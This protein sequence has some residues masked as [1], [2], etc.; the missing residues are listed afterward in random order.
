MKKARVPTPFHDVSKYATNL[1]DKI[2]QNREA[3]VL[4]RQ[5]KAPER[6]KSESHF[7]RS[8]S[9]LSPQ[10]SSNSENSDDLLEGLQKSV[11]NTELPPCRLKEAFLSCS[12]EK[13]GP[14]DGEVF[15]FSTNG[16]NSHDLEAP[17]SKEHETPEILDGFFSSYNVSSVSPQSEYSAPGS[18][19][20]SRVASASFKLPSFHSASEQQ[21][22]SSSVD[23]SFATRIGSKAFGE[24]ANNLVIQR[25]GDSEFDDVSALMRSDLNFEADEIEDLLEEA[26]FLGR[27]KQGVVHKAEMHS[28]EEKRQVVIKSSFF[29]KEPPPGLFFHQELT[30]HHRSS[31]D[32]NV[33]RV[34]FLTA[35]SNRAF[36]V[37]PYCESFLDKLIKSFDDDAESNDITHLV[38]FSIIA[39]VMSDTLEGLGYMHSFER[40]DGAVGYVHRDIKPENIGLKNDGKNWRW[41]LCDLDASEKIGNLNAPTAG[42]IKYMHPGCFINKQIELSASNDI[43]QLGVVLLEM[44]KKAEQVTPPSEMNMLREQVSWKVEKFQ[45]EARFLNGQTFGH[46]KEEIKSPKSIEDI[47]EQFYSLG[48]SMASCFNQTAIASAQKTIKLIKRGIK[49]QAQI[50]KIDLQA[51][52]RRYYDR[53]SDKEPSKFQASFFRSSSSL[54]SNLALCSTLPANR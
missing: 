36:M 39:K 28:N 20:H 23:T 16:A 14:I 32:H 9:I 11:L 35:C 27:G 24:Q 4:T 19:N 12:P 2:N 33:L 44:L 54:E 8:S 46:Y 43:Y 30:Q 31:Y 15:C 22:K 34:Y 5:P 47:T 42:T 26:L 49:E 21:L 50:Y 37:L 25:S 17:T 29:K 6:P 3:L 45:E 41:V 1:R 10:K 18:V 7:F 51:H 40:S 52:N 13:G 48:C 38:H 53:I